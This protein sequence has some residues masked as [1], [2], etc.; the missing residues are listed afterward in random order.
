MFIPTDWKSEEDIVWR[1]EYSN[2]STVAMRLLAAAGSV[3]HVLDQET[4]DDRGTVTLARAVGG[5]RFEQVGF[6]YAGA[7]P[8]ALAG[9]STSTSHP[10]RR[11]PSWAPRA[12]VRRR[13]PR[14]CRASTTRAKG[15]S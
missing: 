10:A 14:C 9:I 7:G 6:S 5:V 2:L 8:P 15:A 11:W 4:E 1:N 13:S 3:F 12:P